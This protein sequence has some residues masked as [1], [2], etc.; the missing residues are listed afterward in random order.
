VTL[1]DGVRKEKGVRELS[2]FLQRL[3]NT[4]TQRWQRAH[5]K[6]GYGQL[7]QGRFKSFPVETDDHFYAAVRY[8]ERPR[9]VD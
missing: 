6:T 3:T 9:K 2:A 4:H 5:G 8:V 1:L 7:Y